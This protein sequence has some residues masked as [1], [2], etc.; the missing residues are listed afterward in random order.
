MQNAHAHFVIADF[1]HRLNDGFGRTLNVSFDHDGQF[2]D[3]FIRLGLRQKLIQGCCSTCCGAFVFGNLDAVIRNLAGLCFGLHHVQNVT[4]FGCAV[5]AQNLNRNGWPR[6]FNAL[7]LIVDQRADFTPLLAHNEDIALFQR[8][9]L[10]QNSRNRATAHIQLRLDDGPFGCAVRV[11]LQVKQ[12]G[13]KRDGFK[14]LIQT[15]ASG[16][17]NFD[18][19]HLT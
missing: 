4:R 6:F 15:L 13:L 12:F 2:F 11:R 17:G 14:Q 8:A 18:I 5:Q 3:V 10:H 16:G 9:A 1:F 19:L 7:A